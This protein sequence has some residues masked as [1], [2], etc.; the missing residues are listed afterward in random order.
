MG[1]AYRTFGP[2][3]GVV[4]LAAD[5]AK[6]ALAVWVARQLAASAGASLPISAE[7][8]VAFGGMA[9]VYGASYSV[10]LKLSGGKSVG[11]ATGVVLS[12]FR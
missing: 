4:V 8:L 10:F 6:G 3:G 1:N 7:A 2:W 5:I 12:L 9:A 11:A